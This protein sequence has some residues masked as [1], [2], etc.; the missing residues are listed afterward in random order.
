MRKSEGSESQITIK[1]SLTRLYRSI[2]VRY[3]AMV[4]AMIFHASKIK[5]IRLIRQLYP[6][7]YLKHDRTENYVATKN[8]DRVKFTSTYLKR[9]LYF[10]LHHVFIP[11]I[12]KNK[13][14]PRGHSIK[15]M[16]IIEIRLLD[17]IFILDNYHS[18][19]QECFR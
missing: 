5:Y 7:H 14:K 3:L 13:C 6:I 17:M 15:I 8:Y 16:K 11:C 1:F 19:Y 2:F 18:S 9:S 10:L 12:L 4:A